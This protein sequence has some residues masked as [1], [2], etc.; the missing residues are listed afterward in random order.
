M[1]SMVLIWL[2]MAQTSSVLCWYHLDYII[3]IC[4]S[5]YFFWQKIVY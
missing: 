3:R 4:F 5:Y 1:I 2:S